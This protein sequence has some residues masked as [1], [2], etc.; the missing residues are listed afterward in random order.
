MHNKR[1]RPLAAL[2]AALV[3]IG[4]LLAGGATPAYAKPAVGKNLTPNGD[5]TYTLSLSVTGDASSSHSSTNAN[6]VIVFDSSGSMKEKT[7]TY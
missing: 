4:V 2:L 1:R 5:G 7:Y 3:A 6:V